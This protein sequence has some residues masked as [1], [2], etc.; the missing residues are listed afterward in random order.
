MQEELGIQESSWFVAEFIRAQV[1]KVCSFVEVEFKQ[2]LSHLCEV[3][4]KE[5]LYVDE[6]LEKLLKK[7]FR[8]RG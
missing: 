6:S 8:V 7:V 2:H 1:R 4:E 5:N 3:L